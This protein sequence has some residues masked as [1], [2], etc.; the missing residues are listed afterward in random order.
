[1]RIRHSLIVAALA[2]AT[3]TV[4]PAAASASPGPGADHTR[5]DSDHARPGV[6]DWTAHYI[7]MRAR[8]WPDAFPAGDLGLLRAV[9]ETNIKRLDL[10]AEAWRPWRSYAA[11]HLWNIPTP[12]RLQKKTEKPDPRSWA[13][14]LPDRTQYDIIT[15]TK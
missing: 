5:S 9:G 4:A 1:M 12:V 15:E 14:A 8:R 11:M 3:L 13:D 10:L 6:G 2:A 7:A